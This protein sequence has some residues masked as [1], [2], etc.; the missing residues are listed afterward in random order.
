MAS[1][2]A[3]RALMVELS[4]LIGVQGGRGVCTR[5]W[6]AGILMYYFHNNFLK[7]NNRKL[8]THTKK[9]FHPSPAEYKQRD[10]GQRRECVHRETQA[11]KARRGC[12]QQYIPLLAHN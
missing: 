7:L 4:K 3:G 1:H 11:E 12:S 2:E 6:E 10:G 5:L 8:L 9:Q